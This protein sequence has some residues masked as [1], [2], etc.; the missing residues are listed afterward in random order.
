MS[1]DH[2]FGDRLHV[3]VTILCVLGIVASIT[4]LPLMS[5]GGQGGA[6]DSSRLPADTIGWATGVN[7]L[8]DQQVP[9][10]TVPAP[11]PGRSGLVNS[12]I[13]PT[14][15]PNYPSIFDNSWI[16]DDALAVIAW[17]LE[18][19]CQ[20]ARRTLSAIDGLIDAEGKLSFA[21]NTN[22]AQVA[23]TRY[24]TG[25]IA[26]VGYAFVFYQNACGDSQFQ[27]V[28]ESIAGWVLTMQNP[29][30]GSVKGGPD[31]NWFSTEHNIDAFFFLR[32]IGLLTNNTLYL[33]AATQI[34]QSLL[35]YHWNSSY[36]CFQQGIDDDAKA[37]DAASWGALFLLSIGRPAEGESCLEFVEANFSRE[38]TY[39]IGGVA[40]NIS[41]Y[42]PHANTDFVWSEGSL[43]V[44]LAY[45]RAGNQSRY[46]QIVSEIQKM[47]GLSGGVIYAAPPATDFA[48]WESVAGT[49]WMVM[50]QS[51]Q[52]DAFWEM[53][54]LV[55]EPAPVRSNHHTQVMVPGPSGVRV[56]TWSGNLFYPV[57]LLTI[58]GRGLSIDLALS[59]NSSWHDYATNFGYGW[60]FSYNVFYV[61]DANGDITVVW[62][63]GSS[64]RFINNNGSFE[65]PLDV[66]DDFREYAPGKYLLKTKHGLEY[67]FDS[68]I[69]KRLTRIQDP[70]G[71]ALT[72]AY[73][74]DMRLSSITDA[75]GRQMSLTYTGAN[76]TTI[77]DPN[78]TPS[79]SIQLQYDA[80]GNLSRIIDPLGNT[81]VYGYDVGHFLTSI[82]PPLGVTTTIT[83]SNS[84]V[85]SVTG[86]STAKSFSYD[87]ANRVTTM[88]D[89]APEGNQTTRFSYD[90]DGRIHTIED[91]LGNLASATW[92]ENNNLT[93]VTDENG[94]TTTYVYDDMG[95]LSSVTD[96]SDSTTT[97]TYESTY[98]KLTG[99]TNAHRRTTHYAYDTRG[100]LVSETDPLD[101]V[102]SYAYNGLGD[103]V[104][105]TD[106]NGATTAYAYDVAGNPITVTYPLG[107]I[108]R[109]SYDGVGNMVGSAN[110]HASV[111]Y[112]YDA[113]GRVTNVNYISHGKSIS[114][115]YDAVGNRASMADPAGGVTTYTYDEAN[116]LISLTNPF[117]QT[118]SFTYD[119]RGRLI[120]RDHHNGTYTTYHYDRANHLLS[121]VNRK[122]SGEVISSYTYEHD[123]AGNR[124]KMIEA[125][126]DE[127]TYRYDDLYRLTGVTYPD[128]STVGYV[129]DSV[130]NRLVMTDTTGTTGYSYDDSD[131]LQ[132]AGMV[133]YGWDNNG[134]MIG[135]A[136]E[137]GATTYTYDYENRLISVTLPG[138]STDTF[139]YYPDGRR[140]SHTSTSG[141][142]TIYLYDG[143]NTLMETNSGGATTARYT[144]AGIDGW[145]SMEQ[146]GGTTHYY[147]QDGLRS[148]VG[149]TDAD[150]TVAATYQ[151]DVFGSIKS[152]TGSI[153]NPHLFT[154]GRWDNNS[155]LYHF[156]FRQYDPTLGRFITRD[157]WRGRI[158][159]PTAL[160]RYTYV[161]NNPGG[162]VD[163]FG[164]FQTPITSVPLPPYL[165]PIYYGIPGPSVAFP[166][167]PYDDD[168]DDPPDP[169]DNS[170]GNTGDESDTPGL[171][172]PD[173]EGDSSG[174]YGS[175][176]DG[177]PAV[178]H[179]SPVSPGS[180]SGVE[181]GPLRPVSQATLRA[182]AAPP[183]QALFT[184]Q[185]VLPV[186]GPASTQPVFVTP[187]RTLEVGNAVDARAV[188]FRLDPN[189]EA[190]TVAAALVTKTLTETYHH[191][192]SVCSRFHGYTLD[193]LMPVALPGVTASGSNGDAPRFWYSSVH[194]GSKHE[195]G[196]VFAVFVNEAERKFVA[197][198][199]WIRTEYA[200]HWREPS[201]QPFDYVL[202]Y[203]IWAS[204]AL[205]AYKLLQG[206]FQKLS[207]VGPGWTI[208]FINNVEP[209]SP[210]VIMRSAGLYGDTVWITVQSRLSEPRLVL[211]HGTKRLCESC[212][213]RSFEYWRITNP[214]LS[215]VKL[216]LGNIDN[217]VV[218]SEADGFLDKIYV[219]REGSR[220]P[221]FRS[222]YLPAIFRGSGSPVPQQPGIDIMWPPDNASVI[223]EKDLTDEIG[224]H[225][226]TIH[227]AVQ[228]MKPGWTVLV[229][230]F[231]DAWYPQDP[232]AIQSGLWGAR[233]HLEGQGIYNNHKI[234]VTLKDETGVAIATATVSNIVRLN[235]CQ[236]Q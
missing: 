121:L 125:N 167:H 20:A 56:N 217:A 6:A 141:E 10:S 85:T 146:S 35:T 156:R 16:Y 155:N 173:T 29:T 139:T 4:P 149:L 32:D 74:A 224:D 216:P 12:Y 165:D 119:S 127:T 128:G 43:G 179:G 220:P 33:D 47:R 203:Q 120:R 169:P 70:N 227:G 105:R 69:H 132:S 53:G 102:T 200:C 27:S 5:A 171:G 205:E 230:V 178:T 44:A 123:A 118:T 82:A 124:T 113:L 160:H 184:L 58:P 75:S 233:V 212:P 163:P 188:D 15:D 148:I 190:S 197:D 17:S 213:D 30:I 110:A 107:G 22:D 52:L 174:P 28:A 214:G 50:V 63:D 191:D 189:I 111:I 3:G 94:N 103:L 195:E 14:S 114:Y 157:P 235:P 71:N 204:S 209:I 106:A 49:A 92:D 31:V 199:R 151:Y 55:D 215:F 91:S 198:S 194:N 138:G 206:V 176:G 223:V 154:G 228:G 229:E 152:Q 219:A 95:N 236:A 59:Y 196:L 150:Q 142:T 87:A 201:S 68:P 78:A 39:N 218:F 147:H 60:Q 177:S 11:A 61:R 7:W 104:S 185:D 34:K 211:F 134:N 166:A 202:N 108:N 144:S 208:S 172:V 115:T 117:S 80:S 23:D 64:D 42:T 25:A 101:Y 131:R 158:S 186:A 41:G 19:E 112:A 225:R 24:R 88:T 116:R 207:E 193:A 40:Q 76:L 93:S 232:V 89:A 129:Y 99:V 187:T 66:F 140:L 164:L 79:R 162:F 170:G 45:L 161:G 84:A 9:N 51:D 135:K 37:L 136:D 175:G 182:R 46:S 231:T 57:S 221:D 96:A 73:D 65:S 13:I 126:G 97:Y 159:N 18:G 153:A 38:V 90:A 192:Y 222:V 21:Y 48:D 100:N 54:L 226:L 1:P 62:E 133:T 86:E 67:Y 168:D 83:Y 77:T 2:P 180:G 130:G 210:N 8:L 72:F 81:A 145:L 143:F 36:G 137:S 26:W 183:A 98:N 109:Y 234:R 122:S 181:S